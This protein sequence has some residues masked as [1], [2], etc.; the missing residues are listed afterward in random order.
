MSQPAKQN[1]AA[2]APVT[3]PYAVISV[4]FDKSKDP[5]ALQRALEATHIRLASSNSVEE[6]RQLIDRLHPIAGLLYFGAGIDTAAMRGAAALM[7]YAPRLR[8]IALV[9]PGVTRS[10]E[11]ATLVSKGLIH[12]FHSLPVCRDRLMFS[13]GHIAGLVAL[14][15]SDLRAADVM[16]ATDQGEAHIV[17]A[18]SSLARVFQQIRKFAEVDAPVLVT[19]ETG[20]GKELAA[21]AI[22]DR[23]PFRKGPFVSINCAGLPTSIIESE[24][25]GYERGAFT[26]AIK[27][28]VGRI[29]A[30]RGG[31][32]FLD[33]I[34][35]LPIEVQGHLLRF[36]QEKTIERL[37]GTKSITVDTRVIAATNVSLEEAIKDGRFREDLYYRL[38]VLTID[39]PPLRERGDDIQLLATYFLRKFSSELKLPKLGFHDSALEKMQR[40]RWPGNVRELI[41]TIRRA[42]VMGEGRWLMAPDITF[43]ESAKADRV[44]LPDLATARRTVEEKL[45]RDALRINSGNIKRAAREL[46]VSRVTFYRLMEKYGLQQEAPTMP[47]HP[48]PRIVP[49]RP[50]LP[51]P[52]LRK[53]R[54]NGKGGLTRR[55]ARASGQDDTE[56]TGEAAT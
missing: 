49:A 28:K 43:S 26:G 41:S 39:M 46:G 21:R 44:A 23:S 11:L 48:L 24:L 5:A 3:Q 13:I 4:H 37:G 14:E 51:L 45:M 52:P 16:A 17:G 27:Q 18:S 6:A 56:T 12:D 15:N 19:G 35:D 1:G 53:G 34:G 36:L 47:R 30:A 25:F 55:A 29:E 50:A 2:A 8:L 54:G 9:E 42:V 7:E 20:T 31:T 32:L 22:H 10:S 40:Y 38:N 33:E